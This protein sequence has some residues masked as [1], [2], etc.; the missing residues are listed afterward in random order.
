MDLRSLATMTPQEVLSAAKQ[1]NP[2]AITALMNRQLQPKGIT[3]SINLVQDCLYVVL[4]AVQ[5][6]D[7]QAL[8]VYVSKGTRMLNIAGVKRLLIYGKRSGEEKAAWTEQ[9]DLGEQ[10]ATAQSPAMIVEKSSS[11]RADFASTLKTGWQ[12]A[13]AAWDAAQAR[14]TAKQIDL[15]G[16]KLTRRS[17]FWAVAIL[18]IVSYAFYLY[19]T[20]PDRLREQSNVSQAA[21]PEASAPRCVSAATNIWVGVKLYSGDR[22]VVEVGTVLGGSN[23]H[24]FA[25]GETTDSV[26]ILFLSGEVEWKPRR[27]ITHQSF[28]RTDDPAT[29]QMQWQTFDNE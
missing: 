27:T 10:T 6:P 28:V 5:I 3:A 25:N 16:F 7:Q 23:H 9:V 1:G 21:K 14:E 8:V 18:A 19:S 26:K 24:T 12:K 13:N 20:S 22:C 15:H 11:A 29:N 2:Q 17:L 4:E